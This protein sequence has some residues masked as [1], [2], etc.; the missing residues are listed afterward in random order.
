MNLLKKFIIRLLAIVVFLNTHSLPGYT[1]WEFETFFSKVNKSSLVILG[2]CN[3]VDSNKQIME[4]Y[5]SLGRPRPGIRF[6]NYEVL[7]IWKGNLQETNIKIDYGPIN[8][9]SAPPGGCIVAPP[10][11]S[12]LFY[13]PRFN[14]KVVLFL[15]NEDN[16]YVLEAKMPA[17]NSRINDRFKDAIEMAIEYESLGDDDKAKLIFNHLE[18]DNVFI[19]NSMRGEL[20]NVDHK[21]FG[22]VIIP[23]LNNKDYSLRLR[24]LSVLNDARDT[25]YAPYIIP[26]LGDTSSA[27]RR[28]AVDALRS[29]HDNRTTFALINSYNDP[30]PYVRSNIVTALNARPL[31]KAADFYNDVI[32]IYYHAAKDTVARVRRAGV[33]ALGKVG[34]QRSTNILL[35]ALKDKDSF[36]QSQTALSLKMRPAPSIVEPVGELLFHDSSNVISAALSCLNL[37]AERNYI[38]FENHM[39]IIER[40]RELLSTDYTHH[41]RKYAV[42]ILGK[43]NDPEI[44]E[45][46]PELINDKDSPVRMEAAIVMGNSQNKKYIPYLKSAI[47]DDRNKEIRKRIEIFL[48]KLDNK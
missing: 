27:L 10:P 34:G 22:S 14:E 31:D 45:K 4:Y 18:S 11:D 48:D 19:K 43:I 16:T 47:D 39:S 33:H 2:R 40:C 5:N 30:D 46:L 7:E 9:I 25:L 28:K 26:L 8:E 1:H 37:F 12:L 6:G 17:G 42:S 23:L 21:K 36:V 41:I 20:R 44:I 32:S 29:I 3:E 13:K 24:A 15:E 38:D 35:E